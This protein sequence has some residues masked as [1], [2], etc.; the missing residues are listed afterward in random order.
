MHG[1]AALAFS[2]N[3]SSC[4][5]RACAHDLQLGIIRATTSHQL[6]CDPYEHHDD[7]ALHHDMRRPKRRVDIHDEHLQVLPRRVV[8][9]RNDVVAWLI[10]QQRLRGVL[11]IQR[12]RRRRREETEHGRRC[13]R[14]WVGN[15]ASVAIA[16]GFDRRCGWRRVRHRRARRRSG[17]SSRS[18]SRIFKRQ[19]LHGLLL[20][21][22]LLFCHRR[23][24]LIGW[25]MRC[26][27]NGSCQPRGN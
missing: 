24:G 20:L 14:R 21:L 16:D 7:D 11:V 27:P 15:S 3:P 6:P 5:T 13:R 8:A 2:R 9:V 17:G 23:C 19:L 4:A 26:I 10:E 12:S 25:L 18:L 22:S 1:P